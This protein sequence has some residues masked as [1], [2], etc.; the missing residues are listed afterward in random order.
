[1]LKIITRN[2]VLKKICTMYAWTVAST[3]MPSTVDK[4]P[5]NLIREDMLTLI[6]SLL[7]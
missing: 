6:V 4:A 5:W 7:I 3:K 2:T 1:M